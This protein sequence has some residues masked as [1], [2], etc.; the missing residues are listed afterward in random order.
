VDSGSVNTNLETFNGSLY[1]SGSFNTVLNPQNAAFVNANNIALWNGASWQQVDAGVNGRVVNLALWQENP[2]QPLSTQLVVAGK[3]TQAGIVAATG[4]VTRTQA[5][6]WNALGTGVS[7]PPDLPFGGTWLGPAPITFLVNSPTDANLIVGGMLSAGG[8][9]IDEF[10]RWNGSAWSSLG[11]GLNSSVNTVVNYQN[12]VVAG[13]FFTGQSF[14]GETLFHV[15]RFDGSQWHTLSLDG[16]NG[17]VRSLF[18]QNGIV[19]AGGDFTTMDGVNASHI[20][21]RINGEWEALGNGINGPVHAIAFF[22]GEIIAGGAFNQAGGI[23]VQNIAAWNGSTWRTLGTGLDDLVEGLAVFNNQLVAVGAFQTDDGQSTSLPGVAVWNGSA[24]LQLHQNVNATGAHAVVV[25]NGQLHLG[26]GFSGGVARFTG[27]SLETV[28]GGVSNGSV[29]ALTS[30]VGS[31]YVGGDFQSPQP[32]ILRWTGAQFLPLTNN[33]NFANFAGDVR[34]LTPAVSELVVG[35]NFEVT[36]GTGPLARKMARWNGSVWRSLADAFPD[37]RV[38]AVTLNG[39]RVLAGGEFLQISNGTVSAYIGERSPS[40]AFTLQPEP[41]HLCT[42]DGTETAVFE[43]A[44]V[45]DAG[46]QFRWQKNGGNLSDSLRIS[47]ATTQ[48]LS[49]FSVVPGDAGNYR[50]RVT[51]ECGTETFSDTIVLDFAG[52]CPGDLNNDD[53]VNLVDA[54]LFAGCLAG[55]QVTPSCSNANRAKFD[56]DSDIDLRDTAAFQRAFAGQ[57]P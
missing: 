9:A 8:T 44:I 26:G 10:A 28:G 15:G 30:L 31:L 41:Q 53:S 40:S 13:G 37:G 1:L 21:A 50:L 35:G 17:V 22:G 48:M 20:A 42:G 33:G 24:W 4:I 45:P 6:Q 49:I 32:W 36:T 38:L 3:F 39:D 16:T 34:T 29:Y 2:S 43:A 54:D 25:H 55:P 57:C 27:S 19:Y 7:W 46:T 23:P 47:G 14:Q 52:C 12:E 51:D 11:V 5:G 56:A 18:T